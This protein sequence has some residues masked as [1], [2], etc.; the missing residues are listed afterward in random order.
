MHER[1]LIVDFGSQYTQLIARRVREHHVF[2]QVVPAHEAHEH[3]GDDLKGVI[4]SGGPASAYAHGAP[5]ME[6]AVLESGVPVLG[7]CYGMQWMCETLGGKVVAG[8][9]REFG[10]TEMKVSPGSQ[11]FAEVSS[12]TVVWMSHGDRVEVL[13]EG[14]ERLAHTE[15]C[16]EAAIGDTGRR[17]YGLQFHPEVAHTRQGEQVLRNFLIGVCGASGDWSPGDLAAELIQR[18]RD[19]VGEDGEIVLGLS[20]GVD[21]SV[22]GAICEQ[23]IGRRCHA[24]FVDTGLLRS[25]ERE[26]VEV[27][28]R[29]HF[30]LDLTVVDAEERFLSR[31]AGE[32]DPEKKRKIIGHEFVEVFREEAKR[33]ENARFLG[34]GTLYP[35]VIESVAAHGGAT[36]VIKSHHNVGGLPEDLEM[37]LVEP[38]RLLFKDEVRELGLILGLPEEMVARQPFPGP[39][40][41]VRCVGECTPERVQML[42]EADRIVREEFESRGEHDGVWQYFAVLTGA[43]SVGVMGDQ[44]TYEEACAI[45]AV[46]SLDGM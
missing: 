36:E 25:G 17:F 29:E 38:L 43:R 30:D 21:S 3:L 28:Y 8:H 4:L 32:T 31:L 41:A 26:L 42:R 19:Q 23:A 37:D 2:S 15:D 40:L 33:F 12:E 6:T 16:P 27:K 18:V 24:I 14:F 5:T 35:D 7:I 10:F 39:G 11:L 22:V 45:R 20:G 44:R 34:Q 1:I 9:E 46:Q 13:P